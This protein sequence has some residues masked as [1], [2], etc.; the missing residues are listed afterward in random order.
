[1]E[2]VVEMYVTKIHKDQ[3]EKEREIR[4]TDVN[5]MLKGC[6]LKLNGIGDDKD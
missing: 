4:K 5:D 2:N 6:T 3:E 1:M